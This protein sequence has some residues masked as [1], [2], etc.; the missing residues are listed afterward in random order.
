[1]EA[2]A[3]VEF[4]RVLFFS[5]GEMNVTGKPVVEGAKVVAKAEGNGLG[6]KVR[7]LRF[8]AKTRAH[9]RVGGRACFT[10]IKIES[11]VAPAK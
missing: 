6:E 3:T 11:I 8:K 1:M 9:V 5:D 2:G 4:P 7:G 10:R